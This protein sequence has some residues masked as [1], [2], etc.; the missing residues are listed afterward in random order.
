MPSE[1]ELLTKL[2]ETEERSKSNM[3]RLNHMEKEYGAL[4]QSINRMATAV[5]VLAT[6][7]RHSADEQRKMRETISETN[8]KVASLEIAPS[9]SAKKIK[10]EIIKQAASAAAGTFV[11]ALLTLILK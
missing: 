2:I 11:G 7:Q 5:E 6:E 8:H 4:N 1:Q 10:E 3:H 9:K